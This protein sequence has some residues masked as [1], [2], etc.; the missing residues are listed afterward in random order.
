M[1]TRVLWYTRGYIPDMDR[2]IV[3]L[4]SSFRLTVFRHLCMVLFLKLIEGFIPS[5]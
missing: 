5:L 1:H 4:V 3:R 2:D